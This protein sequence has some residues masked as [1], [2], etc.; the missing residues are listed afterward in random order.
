LKLTNRRAVKRRIGEALSELPARA[1]RFRGA[2]IFVIALLAA[3]V[4]VMGNGCNR[5]PKLRPGW[6]IVSG[7][8]T[9]QGKP[10]PGGEVMWCTTKDGAAI[11]RG[12]H[13]RDNGTFAL[14]TPTGPAKI[15]IHVADLKKNQSSR[16]VEIPSKYSN[17]EQSGLSY[18]AKDGDNKDVK[19][20][21]Q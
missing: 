18:E 3:M 11:L 12:G 19:I 2:D 1:S 16:Y 4:A 6:A 8:V 17:V 20:D 21:L 15:A 13:I 7:T 9:Y 14:D 5:A 10:L